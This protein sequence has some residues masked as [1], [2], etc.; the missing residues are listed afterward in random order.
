MTMYEIL[1]LNKGLFEFMIDKDVQPADVQYVQMYSDYMQM[2]EGQKKVYVVAFLMDK[3]NVSESTVYR[4]LR[5]FK[6]VIV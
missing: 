4:V 6:R 1:K 5:R 3:Y 2:I